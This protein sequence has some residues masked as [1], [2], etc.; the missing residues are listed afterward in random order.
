M[1]RHHPLRTYV[2]YS[3]SD[4]TYVRVCA[5]HIITQSQ[6]EFDCAA[7]CI[8]V[9]ASLNLCKLQS[10]DREQGGLQE[11][12]ETTIQQSRYMQAGQYILLDFFQN[13]AQHVW[14]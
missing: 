1:R 14:W 4:D 2:A 8:V 7:L 9:L 11:G 5:E 12:E 10:A 13:Y 6:P 3:R